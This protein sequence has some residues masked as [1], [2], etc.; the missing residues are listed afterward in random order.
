MLSYTAGHLG[1]DRFMTD[2]SDGLTGLLA[3]IPDFVQHPFS[4]AGER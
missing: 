3:A 2:A 4:S 1:R